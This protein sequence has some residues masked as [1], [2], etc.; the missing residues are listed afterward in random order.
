MNT[1]K[2]PCKLT[3]FVSVSFFEF[4]FSKFQKKIIFEKNVEAILDDQ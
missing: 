2:V 4:Q 1:M 3:A